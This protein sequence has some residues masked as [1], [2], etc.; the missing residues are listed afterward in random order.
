MNVGVSNIH[1]FYYEFYCEEAFLFTG[2]L[3]G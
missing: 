3:M 1:F 2:S